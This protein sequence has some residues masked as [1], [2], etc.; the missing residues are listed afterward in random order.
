MAWLYPFSDVTF[1]GIQEWRPMLGISFTDADTPPESALIDSGSLNTIFGIHVA[2][3]L[4]LDVGTLP[5]HRVTVGGKP[6]VLKLET[7][8][9]AVHAPQRSEPFVWEAKVGF[10]KDW[11]EG[12]GLLG[13]RSFF[14]YFDVGFRAIDREFEIEPR[15]E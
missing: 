7:V 14:H 12:G 6:V 5:E 15:E 4:G 11:T 2:N 9:M 3:D 10:S 1:G 8:R 13:M